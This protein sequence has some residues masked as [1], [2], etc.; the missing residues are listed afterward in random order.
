MSDDKQNS[1]KPLSD[2]ASTRLG[3]LKP[4]VEIYLR[5]NRGSKVSHLVLR[6]IKLA[7]KP[8]AGKRYAHLVENP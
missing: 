1:E 2:V 6:G 3:E 5:K 7:L 4:L 8:Y